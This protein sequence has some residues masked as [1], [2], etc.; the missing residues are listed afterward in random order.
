MKRWN[1]IFDVVQEPLIVLTIAIVL[2]GMS[3]IILSAN[4]ARVYTFSNMIYVSAEVLRYFGGF[5]I[6]NFPFLVMLRALSKRYEGSFPAFIGVVAYIFFHVVTMFNTN[7][8]MPS[9]VYS[10]ILGI[11][12]DVA[13][14]H[15]AGDITRYPIHTGIIAAVIVWG[16][17]KISY[18]QS[19]NRTG[20][21]FF[22]FVDKDSYCLILTLIGSGIAALVMSMAWPFVID[23]L[24][25]IFRFI[26]YDIANPV[27]AFVYGVLEKGMSLL[28]FPS[29][30][31]EPF[32]FGEFGGSWINASGTNFLGDVAI[33]T[34]Q[35]AQGVFNTGAGRF[36]TPHYVVNMFAIPAIVTAVYSMITD[37]MERRKY[38][39]FL[40]IMV[41]LSV[42]FDTSLPIEIF[43]F[44]MCPLLYLM[45]LF[46]V[47]IIFALFQ[48]LE[49]SIGYNY[50]GQSLLGTP[51]SA[52]DLFI[53]FR[54]TQ[55]QGDIYTVLIV[56]VIVALLYF[57]VTRF[58]YK[59]L[60][61]DLMHTGKMKKLVNAF[62]DSVGGVR[63]IKMINSTPTKVIVQVENRTLID[64][65]KLQRNG[66]YKIVETR[67]GYSIYFG[68]ASTMI[69]NVI[70]RAM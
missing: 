44:I 26:A 6:M 50:V 51:G 3:S 19:R 61:L 12:V 69:K 67:A 43:L 64:F 28:N 10:D 52:F 41:I 8:S 1:S 11:H 29:L 5:I 25:S 22:S 16:I 9:T 17:T 2:R 65:S 36:I 66:A 59:H 42:A 68:T 55:I 24:Y 15:V 38:T 32:W 49:V 46:M 39:I 62:V 57:F 47:G 13:R 21:G 35:S 4:L 37:K 30:I 14:L 20:Y 33:W 18:R 23:G 70:E 45:H 27:N 56:G 58:Y 34:A 7:T 31:R 63:N 48:I 40:C 60:A 53:H 54:N